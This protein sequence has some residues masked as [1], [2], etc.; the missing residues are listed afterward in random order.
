MHKLSLLFIP[1]SLMACN[2][3][4]KENQMSKQ[5]LKHKDNREE[6][7]HNVNDYIPNGYEIVVSGYEENKIKA[8]LNKDGISD[9]V[10]LLTN[11]S[12]SKE[13]SNATS[14]KLA[15]FE[16]QNN[17]SF[18]LKSET[19]N[20]TY[21]FIYTNLEQR[22]KVTNT[23]VISLKHQSMR[24]DYELKFRYENTYKDYMLIGSE[25]NNYGN[26]IHDGTG[27][28]STNFIYK[29]RTSIMDE[30]KTTCLDTELKPISEVNDNNIYDLISD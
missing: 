12:K 19:G 2:N 23:N 1:F 14:V 7:K 25:Y 15:I 30:T 5:A 26:V 3:F 8:D 24:H 28:T 29:E 17:G 10:V 16:G 22:I 11:G 6:I 13:Y 21:S 9:Y 20:L 4:E 27:N 18:K